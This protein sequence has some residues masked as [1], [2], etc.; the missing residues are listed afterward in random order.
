M[1][2]DLLGHMVNLERLAEIESAERHASRADA[3]RIPRTRTRRLVRLLAMRPRV[4]AAAPQP[5]TV[6]AAE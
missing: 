2:T 4:R 1:Y 3:I 6:P 5:R